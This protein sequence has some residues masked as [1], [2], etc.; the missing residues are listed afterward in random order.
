MDAG[1]DDF[2]ATPVMPLDLYAILL[3]WLAKGRAPR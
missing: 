3:R 2:I 1:M